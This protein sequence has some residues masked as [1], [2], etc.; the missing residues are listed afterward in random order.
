MFP[1]GFWR[2]RRLACETQAR[3]N[4]TLAK[5][6]ER[7]AGLAV[8]ALISTLDS[9]DS[10]TASHAA[11]VAMW[12]TDIATALDLSEEEVK[13]THWAG[14]MHDVGKI[15]ISEEILLKDPSELSAEDSA[16]LEEHVR[17]GH[18]IL[19]EIH[20]FGDLAEVVLHHHERYDGEG[21]PTGLA[22]KDIP[23]VSRIISVAESYSAM[24]SDRPNRARRSPEMAKSELVANKGTQFDPV[25]VDAFL[26][27]LT[28][29]DDDYQR[30]EQANFRLEFQ[31][32]E[33][34]GESG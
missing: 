22:G 12:A 11:A 18:Q 30:G 32:A 34:L 17:I 19:S 2:R 31:K 8:A 7:L 6:N 1:S 20:D 29:H 23:L 9:K 16:A 28:Q 25:V 21:Y 27:V 10:H 3:E 13:F 24:V 14:L 4:E 33:L 15:G 26:H 5:K